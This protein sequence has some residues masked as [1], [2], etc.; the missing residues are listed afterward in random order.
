MKMPVDSELDEYERSEAEKAADMAEVRE[1]MDR[2]QLGAAEVEP[3]LESSSEA[4]MTGAQAQLVEETLPLSAPADDALDGKVLD[5]FVEDRTRFDFT[6]TVRCITVQVQKKVVQG[7]DGER[8]VVSANAASVG[9][10]RY[11]VTWEL[12]A[13]MTMLVAQYAMPMN[14][15]STLLSTDKK[16]FSAGAL[17]RMFRYVA[18][19]FEP[20]YI[21]LFDSLA[22]ADIL[23]GDDT[24]CRVLEVS[25]YFAKLQD[26]A[27]KP[28]PWRDY[29]DP[30]AAR[31]LLVQGDDS[32]AAMLASEPGFEHPRRNGEGAKRALHTTTLSGRSVPRTSAS[33]VVTVA[34]SSESPIA[35]QTSGRSQ[36]TPNHFVVRP[37]GGNT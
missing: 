27:G 8:R 7:T 6:F 25:R 14:R 3:A 28:T 37:G 19:R 31:E 2:L 29:R 21:T 5:S 13:N 10:A 33:A 11:A 17:S 32:L 34:T 36:A 9:P 20:I 22:D 24:S 16:R 35:C 15:L 18:Q 12:L 30:D 4:F 1:Q 23:S 26:D